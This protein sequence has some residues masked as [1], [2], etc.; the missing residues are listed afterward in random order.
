MIA[1]KLLSQIELTELLQGLKILHVQIDF[2][3]ILKRKVF[4]LHILENVQ[5]QSCAGFMEG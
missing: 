4:Q 3:L 1:A 2:F 5:G